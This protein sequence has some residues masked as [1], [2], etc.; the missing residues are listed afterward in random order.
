ML[1]RA[2]HANVTHLAHKVDWGW[3]PLHYPL[4]NPLTFARSSSK[5]LYR[6]SRHICFFFFFLLYSSIWYLFFMFHTNQSWLHELYIHLQQLKIW[7]PRNIQPL[8]KQTSVSQKCWTR[9]AAKFVILRVVKYRKPRN[10]IASRT[11][12]SSPV[13]WLY[14]VGHLKCL[15]LPLRV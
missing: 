13:L 1:R 8:W 14:I 11:K 7:K 3:A 10:A 9:K 12:L 15:P 4:N 6:L 5:I 2:E